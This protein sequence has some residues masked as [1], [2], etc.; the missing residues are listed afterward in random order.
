MHQPG[1]GAYRNG[2][3]SF[4][5]TRLVCRRWGEIAF[6]HTK[7]KRG[8]PRVISSGDPMQQAALGISFG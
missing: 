7:Q 4:L 2:G 3:V 5:W 8:A 1:V 6:I